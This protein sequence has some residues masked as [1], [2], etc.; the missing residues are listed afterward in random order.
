MAKAGIDAAG[1][2]SIPIASGQGLQFAQYKGRTWTYGPLLA[3]GQLGDVSFAKDGSIATAWGSSKIQAAILSGGFWS[4]P[5]ILS[6]PRITT[7]SPSISIRS[8][9][10]AAAIW[11]RYASNNII[12]S[13][14]YVDGSWSPGFD[15][16]I[17]ESRVISGFSF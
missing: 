13:S 4:G 1:T 8:A 2:V 9:N 3:E 5:S 15:M 16:G 7:V 17:A 6:D 12:Q 11:Y 10:Q 14:F